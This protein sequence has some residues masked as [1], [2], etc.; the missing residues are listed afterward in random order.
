MATQKEKR[1][2]KKFLFFLGHGNNFWEKVHF[3]LLVRSTLF[4]EKG[5]L[6]LLQKHAMHTR[7][8]TK[9]GYKSF[10]YFISIFD[11]EQSSK[12]LKEALLFLFLLAGN[13]SGT[14]KKCLQCTKDYSFT[15]GRMKIL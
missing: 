7:N 8:Y 6:T 14:N 5:L 3:L 2:K 15:Y 13:H 1:H 12:V 9:K 10:P 4:R 11:R